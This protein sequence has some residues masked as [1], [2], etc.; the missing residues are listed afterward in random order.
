M[1]GS[2][3]LYQLS[4]GAALNRRVIVELFL[5]AAGRLTTIRNGYVGD[6]QVRR[7]M[8]RID[9]IK[10]LQANYQVSMGYLTPN[11]GHQ[12]PGT[13]LEVLN[14]DSYFE[15]ILSYSLDVSMPEDYGRRVYAWPVLDGKALWAGESWAEVDQLLSY[16]A[17]TTNPATTIAN[18]SIL[19]GQ[20]QA[21]DEEG[22]NITLGND[23]AVVGFNARSYCGVLIATLAGPAKVH[24][25]QIQ[26][27]K[28]IR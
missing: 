5:E 1:N 8:M 22:T 25:A 24:R 3:R 19:A 20:L 9:A 7:T 27:E 13:G 12:V 21:S 18:P 15:G 28:Q 26:L 10:E 14:D 16:V 6:S 17:G 2:I 4:S 23:C 11:M